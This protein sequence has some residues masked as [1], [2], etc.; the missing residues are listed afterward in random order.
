MMNEQ[1]KSQALKYYELGLFYQEINDY[2]KAAEVFKKSSSLNK[3]H[4]ESWHAAGVSLF[5]VKRQAEAGMYFTRALQEYQLRIDNGDEKAYNLFQT[6]CIQ[7]LF[8]DKEKAIKNLKVAIQLNPQHADQVLQV[9]YFQDWMEDPQFQ[10]A[11]RPSLNHLKKIRYK[12]KPLTIAELNEDQLGKRK[13]F[14]NAFQENQWKTEDFDQLLHSNA[15]S[16]PQ[17]FADYQGNPHLMMGVSYH[18]DED[19]FFLEL[20][21]RQDQED[22]QAYRIYKNANIQEIIQVLVEYQNQLTESNW[23]ELIGALV[24]YCDSMLFEMPDGRK[25]RI[26]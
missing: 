22:E 8:R 5:E 13:I 26:A 17:A 10:E 24:D 21:N 11:L 19:L 2:I 1:M 18:L 15:G 7:A 12:G 3:S 9:E 4:A 23:T 14:L 6:A 16:S 20:Q 25:V